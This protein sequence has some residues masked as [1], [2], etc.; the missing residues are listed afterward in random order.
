MERKHS[1]YSPGIIK[2][3]PDIVS[4]SGTNM[5]RAYARGS[6]CSSESV[7]PR[8]PTCAELGSAEIACNDAYDIHESHRIDFCE[9][10]TPSRTRRLAVII[11]PEGS[12]GQSNGPHMVA[13]IV[14]STPLNVPNCH[15]V[16]H[17]SARCNNR[18]KPRTT[19]DVSGR[20][21]P[22]RK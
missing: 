18:Q 5:S 8:Q 22:G 6:K 15:A 11:V 3:I 1:G 12:I 17:R 16:R 14:V 21:S 4:L 13:G 9:D 19:L 10:G 7:G 2:G 20:C